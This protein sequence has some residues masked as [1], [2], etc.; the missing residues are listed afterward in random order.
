MKKFFEEVRVIQECIA[1]AKR[2]TEDIA[3]CTEDLMVA[4]TA[5]AEQYESTFA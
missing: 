1:Q 4:T 5:N 3:R 2:G